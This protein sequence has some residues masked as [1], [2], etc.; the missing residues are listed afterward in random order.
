MDT[1]GQE[2][3][4]NLQ[5]LPK[6]DRK[7]VENFVLTKDNSVVDRVN[8]FYKKQP[9]LERAFLLGFEG[10]GDGASHEIYIGGGLTAIMLNDVADRNGVQLPEE[11]SA[12]AIN[13][14]I[15]S[16]QERTEGSSEVLRRLYDED[17][18]LFL[19]LTVLSHKLKTKPGNVI[20]GGALMRNI[21]NHIIEG[22]NLG[23]KLS[24]E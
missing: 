10:L 14:C 18:E 11:I 19:G 3:E 7:A 17:G 24:L 9:K 16:M 12:D 5:Q 1:Q 20:Q 21:Y 8:E 13:A 2:S 6:V 22:Q 4:R 15:V 23:K